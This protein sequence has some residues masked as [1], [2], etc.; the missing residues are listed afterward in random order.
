MHVKGMLLA[1][2]AALLLADGTPLT[3]GAVSFIPTTGGL[4]ASG[5]IAA[6]GTFSLRSKSR[7]GAAP[8]EYSVRIEPSD[9][10]VRGGPP[11]SSRSPRGIANATETPV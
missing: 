11:R 3:G 8:G 9:L 10:P 6:D 1:A 2:S 5:K 7:D 4:P